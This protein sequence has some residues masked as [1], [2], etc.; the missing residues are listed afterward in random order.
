MAQSKV[1]LKVAEALAGAPME[2]NPG[3]RALLV[4]APA[5]G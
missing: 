2:R 1:V 4:R 5:I 3:V